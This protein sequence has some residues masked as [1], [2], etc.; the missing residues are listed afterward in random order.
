MD[1]FVYAVA[2]V[3]VDHLFGEACEDNRFDLAFQQLASFLGDVGI[4]L[5]AGAQYHDVGFSVESGFYA[6]F[7]GCE[8]VVVDDFVSG[9]A[10]EVG[11]E[12]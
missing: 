2:F 12:T 8:A 10:E 1:E 3:G 6:L 7:S 11:G 9:T 4:F 5:V